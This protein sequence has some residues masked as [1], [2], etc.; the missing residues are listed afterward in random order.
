MGDKKPKSSS[1]M[2]HPMANQNGSNSK[3]KKKGAAE[4]ILQTSPASSSTAPSI[5]AKD[6]DKKIFGSTNKNKKK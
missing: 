6:N 2:G 3:T 1:V 4:N 5:D